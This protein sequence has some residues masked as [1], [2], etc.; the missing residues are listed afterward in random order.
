MREMGIQG[1]V[2]GRK[3]KTT[4][5]GDNAVQPADLVLREF[6][7]SRPN[8]LWLEDLTYVTTWR[9]FAYVAFIIDV[10]SRLIVGWQVS[11]SLRTDIALDALEQALYNRSGGAGL[12]HHSDRGVQYLSIRYTERLTE[13]GIEFNFLK[14]NDR[15]G[16]SFLFLR[17]SFQ[18]FW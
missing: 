11:S 16:H 15:F 7:A 2:R 10:F 6:K 9:G 3:F 17:H 14:D 1:A 4:A 12:I 13:A 18:R 5:S 8:Q